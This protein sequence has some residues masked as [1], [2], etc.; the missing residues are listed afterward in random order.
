MSKQRPE[1][2]VRA[3]IA[4]ASWVIG[5]GLL[6]MWGTLNLIHNLI[7]LIRGDATLNDGTADASPQWGIAALLIVVTGLLPFLIGLWM[8][9]K[10]WS[11]VE[12]KR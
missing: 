4:Y 1:R 5:A 2:I 9:T 3:V 6:M 12:R 8:A 11:V 7:A 10:A